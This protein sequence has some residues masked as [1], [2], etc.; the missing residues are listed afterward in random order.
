MSNMQAENVYAFPMDRASI[1]ERR[2]RWFVALRSGD[3][4]QTKEYLSIIVDDAQHFCCMGVACHLG[5]IPTLEHNIYS[6]PDGT[7]ITYGEDEYD[8]DEAMSETTL[9]TI[10]QQWLGVTSSDPEVNLPSGSESLA[11]LNDSRGWSFEQIADA[12]EQYGFVHHD[13]W[14]T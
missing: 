13:E 10:G 11:T 2:Q 14:P 1:M 8:N 9:P 6:L 5:K 4:K 3:Y 12:V 7:Y